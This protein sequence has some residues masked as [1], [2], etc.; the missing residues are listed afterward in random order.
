MDGI[1]Y[2]YPKS[3]PVSCGS[4]DLNSNRPGPGPW[5]GLIIGFSIIGFAEVMRKKKTL[6]L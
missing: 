6:R 5:A 2:L 1:S 4:I 3:Q